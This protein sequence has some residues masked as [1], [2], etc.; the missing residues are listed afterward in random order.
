MPSSNFIPTGV[1]VL[2]GAGRLRY[3]MRN[4]R[5]VISRML[6]YFEDAEGQE[7][8]RLQQTGGL[9]AYRY[10]L[11]RGEQQIGKLVQND[12]AMRLTRIRY[13]LMLGEDEPFKHELSPRMKEQT[14]DFPDAQV[15]IT[16]AREKWYSHH[17]WRVRI[18]TERDVIP[19][20]LLLSF[21]YLCTILGAGS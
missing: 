20:L 5:F 19:Y 16:M 4:K 17:H 13:K 1:Q 6:Y 8:M 7:V 2:D 10:E 11:Q 15:E 9:T 12:H 21:G 3:Q 18:A 14:I